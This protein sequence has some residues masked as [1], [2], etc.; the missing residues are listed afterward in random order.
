MKYVADQP[1]NQH[2]VDVE[3]IQIDGERA[4]HTDRQNQ[5][6]Q[7]RLGEAEQFYTRFNQRDG[8]GVHE[9]VGDDQSDIDEIDKSR[10]F[11]LYGRTD[12][13]VLHFQRRQDGCRGGVAG[14]SQGQRRQHR[15]ADVGVVGILDD[16]LAP[17]EKL[18]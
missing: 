15:T 14:N 12:D 6:H 5:R 7:E 9:E 1:G 2:H 16:Q 11:D 18:L 8:H 13:D 10:I 17:R 3:V 4:D